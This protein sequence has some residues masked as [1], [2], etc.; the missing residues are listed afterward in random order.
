MTNKTKILYE[1]IGRQYVP[2]AQAALYDYQLR[3]TNG[4]MLTY[5]KDGLTM[6]T[7]DVQPDTA[8]FKA[9][10]LMAKNAMEKAI[11][12]AAKMQPSGGLKQYTAKQRKL[13]EQFAADMGGMMPLYWESQTSYQIAQAGIDAVTAHTKA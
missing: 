9:A 7:Y 1:K 3:P 11:S 6:W 13:I 10:A 12:E 4:C 2:V 8:S 5:I